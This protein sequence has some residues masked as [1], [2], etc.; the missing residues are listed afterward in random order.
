[1]DHDDFSTRGLAYADDLAATML[2]FGGC[3]CVCT[4]VIVLVS[5]GSDPI[6]IFNEFCIFF[7]QVKITI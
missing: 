5:H 3:V 6:V 2:I 1:M 7:A 4:L